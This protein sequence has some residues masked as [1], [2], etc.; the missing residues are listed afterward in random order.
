MKFG[1]RYCNTGPYIDPANAVE[2]A[3]A[4]EQAGFESIWTVEHVVVP[5]GYQS[6]YPYGQS[7]RMPGPEESPIPDPVL[8]LS[9]VTKPIEGVDLRRGLMLS[10][11]WPSHYTALVVG[12]PE[13]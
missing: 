6:T 7:G 5:E 4:G 9:F 12:Q 11:G 10:R 2:L 13:S 1:I 3:Q 8:P